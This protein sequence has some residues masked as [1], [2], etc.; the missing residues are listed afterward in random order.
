MANTSLNVC[1]KMGT[2]E[3]PTAVV[4]DPRTHT[5]LTTEGADDLEQQQKRPDNQHA[6][7]DKLRGL[8]HTA[9]GLSDKYGAA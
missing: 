6:V 5:V 4:L 2:H 9:W 8:Q 7:L 3:L 1:N